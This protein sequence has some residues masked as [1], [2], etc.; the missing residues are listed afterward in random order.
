MPFAAVNVNSQ[1]YATGY[2]LGRLSIGVVCGL[3][4]LFAGLRKGRPL[5]GVIG[6]LAC[7]PCGFMF[8]WLLA[9]PAS[10]VFRTMIGAMNQPKP[11]GDDGFQD[12]PFNPYANGKQSAF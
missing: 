6:F 2:L 4:P 9:L 12:A 5:T 7:I 8:G 11:S 10:F 1:A 3:W